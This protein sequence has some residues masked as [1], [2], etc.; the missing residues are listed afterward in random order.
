M[1]ERRLCRRFIPPVVMDGITY[2]WI[3]WEDDFDVTI[4]RESDIKMLNRNERLLY[5]KK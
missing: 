5:G 3:R 4:L 1:Y 2:Y